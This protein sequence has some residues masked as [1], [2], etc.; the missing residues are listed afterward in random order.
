MRIL[1]HLIIQVISLL[2]CLSKL[3]LFKFF[4]L[5][6]SKSQNVVLLGLAGRRN[7]IDYIFR[8]NILH[9]LCLI[10]AFIKKEQ[11]F[12][13]VFPNKKIGKI[14]NKKVFYTPMPTFDRLGLENHSASLQF[15]IKNLEFQNN[16]C[17]PSY[18]EVKYWENKGFM[19]KKFKKLKISHPRTI[20]VNKNN[21]DVAL[22]DLKE[23]IEFPFLVKKLF[24]NH[25]RGIYYVQNSEEF[26]SIVV[27]KLNN[28]KI[29]FVIQEV[30]DIDKDMRVV[31]INNKAYLSY[32]RTKE[33]QNVG[34]TTTSTSNGS[35]VQFDVINDKFEKELVNITRILGLRNAAYDV[36][37]TK[38]KKGY[39]I[40]EVSP[41]YIANP[42]PPAKYIDQP[43]T[44]FK[45][46]IFLYS[47]ARI[48][49]MIRFKELK[50]EI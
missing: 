24:S 50:L 11:T 7:V 14:R 31:I 38:N 39:S 48:R 20:I 41:S 18:K 9:D 47:K 40:F 29:P 44:S 1:K 49:Q 36:A 5:C 34:F 26:D 10:I 33:R 6:D 23:S 16:E 35:K 43:Y 4:K 46:S 27:N 42:K 13:I 28:G 8:A 25:S 37:F 2:V 3:N 45:S 21:F 30:L 32:F 22:R 12:K 17:L 19:Y 15:I